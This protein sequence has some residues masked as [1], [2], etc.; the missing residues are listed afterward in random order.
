VI[1][2]S[3]SSVLLPLC[4]LGRKLTV[5]GLEGR[6]YVPPSSLLSCKCRF[7]GRSVPKDERQ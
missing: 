4:T 3:V 5:I 2:S 7:L 6:G 1:L